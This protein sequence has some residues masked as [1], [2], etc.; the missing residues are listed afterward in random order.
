MY[1]EIVGFWET[2][3][4]KTIK[5]SL[6]VLRYLFLCVRF[7]FTYSLYSSYQIA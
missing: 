3:S 1:W 5:E 4:K 7:H 6:L 2:T